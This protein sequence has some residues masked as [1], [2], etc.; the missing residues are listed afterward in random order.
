[1]DSQ[2]PALVSAARIREGID[3]GQVPRLRSR[4]Q[5]VL[6]AVSALGSTGY[7]AAITV[8]TLAAAEI[9]GGPA[10]GGVPTASLTLGTALAASVL[11]SF[12]LRS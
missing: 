9:A 8:G 10:I 4:L 1:M 7:L 2:P 11:S 3:D 6:V 12:M 5:W